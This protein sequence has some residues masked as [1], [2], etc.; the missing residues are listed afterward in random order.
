MRVSIERDYWVWKVRMA[1]V[2]KPREPKLPATRH[3]KSIAPPPPPARTLH[4]LAQQTK[5]TINV[6]VKLHL[7]IPAITGLILALIAVL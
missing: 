6:D 1:Q 5:I 2:P 4:T 7:V 3:A